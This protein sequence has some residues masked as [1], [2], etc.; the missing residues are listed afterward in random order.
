MPV[1]DRHVSPQAMEGMPIPIESMYYQGK[2]PER[3]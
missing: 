1:V 2:R 3:R